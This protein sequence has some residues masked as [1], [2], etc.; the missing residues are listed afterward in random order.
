MFP[1]HLVHDPEQSYYTIP[2]TSINLSATN[3]ELDWGIIPDNKLK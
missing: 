1:A 2:L 3:S